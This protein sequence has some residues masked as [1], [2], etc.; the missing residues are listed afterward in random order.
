MEEI[1]AVAGSAPTE[2]HHSKRAKAKEKESGRFWNCRH[3]SI[4]YNGVDINISRTLTSCEPGEGHRGARE[5]LIGWPGKV[6]VLAFEAVS[7]NAI[8]AES[9]I[10]IKACFESQ[11]ANVSTASGFSPIPALKVPAV[12][13]SE[14][15]MAAAETEENGA[16][17]TANGRKRRRFF[18]TRG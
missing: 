7:D 13:K 6:D 15:A 12:E 9:Q 8:F 18:I 1:Q 5:A 2:Q 3:R 17:R 10:G 4:D 11:P 14:P 16:L